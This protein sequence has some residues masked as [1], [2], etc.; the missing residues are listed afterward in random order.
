MRFG[1]AKPVL[2]MCTALACAAVACA[3]PALAVD[4]SLGAGVPKPVATGAPWT[5]AEISALDAN[6]DIALATGTAL[7]GAHV[8]IYAIDARDGRVLYERNQD[9]AFQPA[10]TFKLLVASAALDKLGPDWRARTT[11][12]AHGPVDAQGRLDGA[13][14]LRGGGD[15]LLR[16]S[17]LGA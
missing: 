7:R 2:A 5:A 10:S 12:T 15:P 6:V 16:A 14:V 3:A 8:G 9:D 11:L 1:P 13:L 17:D 4:R